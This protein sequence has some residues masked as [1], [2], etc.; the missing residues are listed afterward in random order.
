MNCKPTD[1]DLLRLFEALGGALPLGEES[2]LAEGDETERLKRLTRH[3]IERTVRL[4]EAQGL[5]PSRLLTEDPLGYLF[6]A[7]S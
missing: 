6:K 7:L 1:K 4:E 2:I 3:K 5:R